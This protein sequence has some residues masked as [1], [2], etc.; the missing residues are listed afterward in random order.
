ME[1]PT[2]DQYLVQRTQIIPINRK[3]VMEYNKKK[4]KVNEHNLLDVLYLP[5]AQQ[6][7]EISILNNLCCVKPVRIM[8]LIH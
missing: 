4:R 5:I 2:W 8:Q 3:D 6:L 1:N 7:K